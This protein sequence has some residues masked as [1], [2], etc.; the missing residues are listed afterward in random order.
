MTLPNS[1]RNSSKPD[2]TTKRSSSLPCRSRLQATALDHV[3]LRKTITMP[4]GRRSTSKATLLGRN[5][6][7]P[8]RRKAHPHEIHDIF[9]TLSLRK[10]LHLTTT[11]TRLR[12]A[13]HRRPLRLFISFLAAPHR[14]KQDIPRSPCLPLETCPLTLR[15]PHSNTHSNTTKGPRA[16]TPLTQVTLKSSQQAGT[17]VR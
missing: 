13:E 8:I 4:M 14:P 15:I 17:K 12:R 6:N 1:M 10:H 2:V 11:T 3:D 9:T 5:N 7:L 16:S